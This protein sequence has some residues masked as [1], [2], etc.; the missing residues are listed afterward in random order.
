MRTFTAFFFALDMEWATQN[1]IAAQA[2]KRF[3]ND[4]RWKNYGQEAELVR[5]FEQCPSGKPGISPLDSDLLWA[6][7]L[8]RPSGPLVDSPS[9]QSLWSTL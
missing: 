9:E 8:R 1:P 7:L 5:R 4:S 6:V 2:P 3:W